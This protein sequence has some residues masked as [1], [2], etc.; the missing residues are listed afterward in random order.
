MSLLLA[1]YTASSCL[2]VGLDATW[3][4]LRSQTS[5]LKPCD[6]ETVRLDT[7]IG[8]VP[9]V[10]AVRLPAAL[11]NYDCRNNRLAL[12]G[13]QQDDFEATVQQTV[14]QYGA[15]RVG[16]FLGTSTSG[17][18][19]TELA[20]RERPNGQGPLPAW[21]HYDE[22]QNT[23]SVAAFVRAY[24]GLGGPA[25]VVSTACSSTP[26]SLPMHSA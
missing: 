20:Y 7:W 16:V 15:Q 10:D 2:G 12:L 19:Q 13:L 5:G 9:G 8:E 25:F 18:L 24:F 11:Q 14:A 4:A 21:F 26:R 23:Y 1:A 22:T 17:M 3:Q 6:F